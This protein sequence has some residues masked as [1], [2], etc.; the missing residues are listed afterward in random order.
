[1]E[2]RPAFFFRIF[3]TASPSIAHHDL[4]LL[5]FCETQRR[6]TFH[7]APCVFF[8]LFFGCFPPLMKVQTLL[9]NRWSPTP[10]TIFVPLPFLFPSSHPFFPSNPRPSQENRPHTV[11]G[12]ILVLG[13]WPFPLAPPLL[14]SGGLSTSTFL[15][16]SCWRIPNFGSASL[17]PR[18]LV[19]FPPPLA[20]VTFPLSYPFL[21]P[22]ERILIIARV[23]LP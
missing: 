7:P 12:W 2:P 11:L 18:F 3:Y 23:S 1:L 6:F 17:S 8:S 19:Y 21:Q 14:R 16:L 5:S 10:C 20:P 4:P 15:S 22:P 13:L 9:Q